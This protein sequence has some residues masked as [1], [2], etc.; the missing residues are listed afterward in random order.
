[1][2]CLDAQHGTEGGATG[3]TLRRWG[4][5]DGVW[6]GIGVW[7]GC[8]REPTERHLPLCWLSFELGRRRPV[9]GALDPRRRIG[10]G[11]MASAACR[12]LTKVPLPSVVLKLL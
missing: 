9:A 10:G 5:C 11:S 1:M 6:K 4:V 12:N 3:A 7:K 8:E 2:R